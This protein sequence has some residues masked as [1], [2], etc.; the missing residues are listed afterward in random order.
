[1]KSLFLL[2]VAASGEGTLVGCFRIR[3]CVFV[4][5][6]GKTKSSRQLPQAGDVEKK[7][8]K[9]KNKIKKTN[10]N[11]KTRNKK[12]KTKTKTKKKKCLFDNNERKIRRERY[13][14]RHK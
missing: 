3:T 8:R 2:S 6:F 12:K 9:K 1:M 14:D 5:K 7:T 11:K 10:K 4:G 13:R